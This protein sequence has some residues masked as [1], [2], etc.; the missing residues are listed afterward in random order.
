MD[1]WIKKPRYMHTMEY[2]SAL[3]KKKISKMKKQPIDWEK[4]IINYIFD[5]RLI[6]KIYKELI[7]LSSK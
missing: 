6:S 2:S 3:R 4:N 5:K 1:E 7:Q